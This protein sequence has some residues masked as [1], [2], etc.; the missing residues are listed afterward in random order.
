VEAFR[1]KSGASRDSIALSDEVRVEGGRRDRQEYIPTLLF[2]KLVTHVLGEFLEL[3][4][5][6]CIVGVDH[7][8]LQVP[9]TPRE[10][11]E[12]LALLEVGRYLSAYL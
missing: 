12:T 11:L 2:I 1:L 4:F 6:L 10:I 5:R 8:I 7:E 9:E 3:A